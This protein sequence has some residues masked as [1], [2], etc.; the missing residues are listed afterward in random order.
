MNFA[1]STA[2]I[3]ELVIRICVPQNV[4]SQHVKRFDQS[5]LAAAVR[6]IDSSK[7]EC[8]VPSTLQQR[9]CA[10]ATERSSACCASSSTCFNCIKRSWFPPL[11]LSQP[12]S[13]PPLPPLSEKESMDLDD[14]ESIIEH[15]RL[16]EVPFVIPFYAEFMFKPAENVTELTELKVFAKGKFVRFVN[17]LNTVDFYK[18]VE[19]WADCLD[20]G[21]LKCDVHV[22]RILL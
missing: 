10:S 18:C 17:L 9:M 22:D 13:Q 2:F 4:I 8:C 15:E 20:R 12:R 3:Q 1:S 11:P 5:V 7:G 14:I 19:F 6:L 16:A 21:L